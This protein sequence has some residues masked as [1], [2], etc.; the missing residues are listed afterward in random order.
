MQKESI[1]RVVDLVTVGVL[2][3]AIIEELNQAIWTREGQRGSLSLS[4]ASDSDSNEE[5][6]SALPGLASALRMEDN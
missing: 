6:R 4:A 5:R 1:R 2:V 3:K